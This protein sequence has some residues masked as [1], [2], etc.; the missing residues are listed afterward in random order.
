MSTQDTPN[1]Q[2]IMSSKAS[3]EPALMTSVSVLSAIQQAVASAGEDV[4]TCQSTVM[5]V[6]AVTAR[7]VGNGMTSKTSCAG[8]MVTLCAP[9]TPQRIKTAVGAFSVADMLEEA[10][11]AGGIAVAPQPYVGQC[12]AAAACDGGA[13]SDAVADMPR[14]LNGSSSSNLTSLDLG[15][16]GGIQAAD[17]AGAT[18]V[19]Y[20]HQLPG[21]ATA[22]RGASAVPSWPCWG[23][24]GC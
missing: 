11:A 8:K 18:P 14:G 9:A 5:P 12:P 16:Q 22:N 6:G 13:G 24:K 2:G 17:I 19:C 7:Q 20:T 3:G 10:V 1:P 21:A 23:R 4:A 15:M